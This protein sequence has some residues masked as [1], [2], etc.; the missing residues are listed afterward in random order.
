MQFIFSFAPAPYEGAL[1]LFQIFSSAAK[2]IT[3]YSI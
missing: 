3:G 2:I 1:G